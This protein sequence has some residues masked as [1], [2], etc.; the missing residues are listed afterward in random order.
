MTIR[1]EYA[2]IIQKG[3][4]ITETRNVRIIHSSSGGTAGKN[5]LSCKISLPTAWIKEL[6]L[7]KEERN[8]ELCFD[9]QTICIRKK[10]TAAAFVN[11]KKQLGHD[12]EKYSLYDNEKL[13]TVIYADMTDKT[14]FAEN[15]TENI[16]KTAFGKN[17]FPTWENFCKFIEERCVPRG[18]SGLRE[19][20]EAIGVDG[21]RPF[22]IIT[23]TNGRMAEDNQWIKIEKL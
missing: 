11:S 9:G 6:G 12:L 10:Q 22:E 23:K 15:F 8:A 17:K 13:C 18:R 3:S 20:L 5:A 1:Y 14:I 7:D 4:D 21:Y 16:V 2:I 19:Y